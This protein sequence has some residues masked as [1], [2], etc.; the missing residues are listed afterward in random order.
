M[1]FA[2]GLTTLPMGRHLHRMLGQ[3]NRTGALVHTADHV[4]EMYP[5]QS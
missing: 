4:P 2:G 5:D 3:E 1:E